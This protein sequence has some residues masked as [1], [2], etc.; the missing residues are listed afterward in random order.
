MRVALLGAV[1][2]GIVGC[3]SGGS[4]GVK[5]GDNA[6]SSIKVVATTSP[7]SG[8]LD[9]APG[10]DG[11]VIYFTAGGTS[12][13]S[14]VSVAGT[15]GS[16]ST[17]VAGAPL[18]KPV[19]LAVA[20]D[21]RSVFVADAGAGRIFSVPS[22]GGAPTVVAGT[23]GR[24]PR[25]LDV[26]V[27]G[28]ADIIYFTGSDP[29]DGAPGLFSVPA[30]GGTVTVVAKGAPLVSPDA[31]VVAGAGTAY[32]TD[33]GATASAGA[34]LRVSAGSV[35]KVAG[36]RLGDPG[37]VSLTRDGKTLLVSSQNATTGAD[38]VLMIDVASGKAGTATKVIG[39][40]HNSSGGLHRGYRTTL[41]AW[42]DVSRGG[43]VYRVE[44]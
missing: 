15:G 40:N 4:N 44:L 30:A 35:V 25:G 31:V 17:L 23:E 32:V 11:G 24:S 37:G 19:G 41:F 10:P 18:V 8:P 34:V 27:E 5:L 9:A 7:G 16:T 33:H 22:G 39:V 21:G 38:Q 1:A 28:G 36:A 14:I 12:G 42:A 29:A 6:I 13:P 26:T 2:L 43:R 3:S 20:T